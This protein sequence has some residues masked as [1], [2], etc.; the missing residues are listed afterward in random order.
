M[1]ESPTWTPPE[2]SQPQT[3]WVPPE[4]ISR[5]SEAVPSPSVSPQQVSTPSKDILHWEPYFNGTGDLEKILPKDQADAFKALAKNNPEQKDGGARRAIVKAFL[6]DQLP[7]TKSL[8]DRNLDV[9]ASAYGQ[10]NLGIK[11]HEVKAEDLYDSI[12]AH[13]KS[14]QAE[15]HRIQRMQD[16]RA[17]LR[18]YGEWMM[19]HGPE[20]AMRQWEDFWKPNAPLPEMKVEN[21]PPSV[22]V[23]MYDPELIAGVWNGGI[24]PALDS[25]T[26]T[27]G[28]AAMVATGGLSALE[29]AG[30]A[31]YA[32]KALT[33]IKGFFTAMMAKTLYDQTPEVMRVLN[34]PKSTREQK[35][36]AV[37]GEVTT[38]L[39]TVATGLSTALDL[40]PAERRASVANKVA[41]SESPA[42]AANIL[43]VEANRVPVDEKPQM[44]SA[45]GLLDG[46]YPEGSIA[47][48]PL[49]IEAA[50]KMA[51]DGTIIE[52]VSHD[53]IAAEGKEGFTLSNGE[54]ATRE[55]AMKVA[56]ASGQMLEDVPPET[57]ELHSHMVDMPIKAE[58][59]QSEVAAIDSAPASEHL[60]SVKK[61]S[62]NTQLKRMGFDPV[63]PSE[64]KTWSEGVKG[65]MDRF[66]KDPE[67]G[68]NLV[69]RAL[70]GETRFNT[71]D[72]WDS[73]VY[74][75]QLEDAVVAAEKRYDE[76]LR[77]GDEKAMAAADAE[78]YDKQATLKQASQAFNEVMGSEAGRALNARKA[79]LRE[80]FSPAALERKW[81]KSTGKAEVPENVQKELK[82]K[83]DK[84]AELEDLLKKSV[85]SRAKARPPAE[86]RVKGIG[87][88]SEDILGR[89]SSRAEEAR[90][91]LKA[92]A[93]RAMAGI[94]PTDL[95]DYAIVAAD[96]L[97]KGVTKASEIS[98]RMVS[99]FGEAIRPHVDSLIQ[100]AKDS[101]A[102]ERYAAAL[103]QR[104]KTLETQISN[105]KIKIEEGDLAKKQGKVDRPS[106]EAIEVLKQE[107]DA[108]NKQLA[109]ARKEAAK[110]SEAETIQKKV[111]ALQER[112][113]EKRRQLSEGAPATKGTAVN[114]PQVEAIELARQEL[115][116]VNKE[117][118]EAR[119]GPPV[120]KEESALK[121]WRTRTQKEIAR[122]EA[123]E[124]KPERVPLELPYT[125]E[126]LKLKERV[127]TLKKEVAAEFRANE[128]AR[129]P[130]WIKGVD[131]VKWWGET[132]ILGTLGILLK[133][134]ASATWKTLFAPVK[135]VFGVTA[136][137]VFPEAAKYQQMQ[138]QPTYAQMLATEAKAAKATVTRGLRAFGE[139]AL[140]RLTQEEKLFVPDSLPP[141]AKDFIRSIHRALHI[142]AQI[143]AFIRVVDTIE[144]NLK[145]EGLGHTLQDP[146]VYSAIRV[147][148]YLESYRAAYLEK[149]SLLSGG[150]KAFIR[151]IET[152]GKKY[153]AE[154]L[155][156]LVTMAIELDSPTKTVPVN[157]IGQ[158][159]ETAFGLP[160][161]TLEIFNAYRKGFE[162]MKKG[163]LDAAFRRVKNGSVGAL[164]ML[165]AWYAYENLGGSKT[166]GPMYDKP[167]K[168][169][170]PGMP[171]EGQVKVGE[172]TLPELG[173]H[174]ETWAAAQMVAS[175]R[176]LLDAQ[177]GKDTVDANSDAILRVILGEI[178]D[179][180]GLKQSGLLQM[181]Q[182]KEPTKTASQW[183]A[184]RIIPG[185]VAQIARWLDTPGDISLETFMSQPTKRYPRTGVEE[186][187]ARIPGLRE[188]VPTRRQPTT[189]YRQ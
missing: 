90:A 110:P 99:E 185:G 142:P 123:R 109:E 59:V 80:D 82:D 63:T 146:A 8:I 168:R 117:L 25:M 62:V 69:R 128:L 9:V 55:E 164:A 67:R 158:I 91:R 3:S 34:D 169:R 107:R 183:A 175:Y 124:P 73:Q 134:P 50:A 40:L 37:S 148:A 132:A 98:Q 106:P 18:A 58:A 74:Q 151:A 54:F 39:F 140:N 130:A 188:E 45:A 173:F 87:K 171:A 176:H 32:A 41:T 166:S 35:I 125:P 100:M 60:T 65:A 167:E 184:A 120:S 16:A 186:F 139:A 13:I 112:I 170:R 163:D 144:N 86:P 83:A 156:A 36:A 95:P 181:A 187:K 126:D 127:E 152:T 179:M 78:L 133:I 116:Q 28:A 27:G 5:R 111:D 149:D 56:K 79:M 30:V 14:G 48:A 92:K 53:K 22:A 101:I 177:Y 137:K 15:A 7:E 72:V 38:G 23:P 96:L 75:R 44:I 94:D 145:A 2:V 29:K 43:R 154:T 105:L 159:G 33:G 1:P 174:N 97:A 157:V 165:G 155:A 85:E 143:N 150:V 104:K 108:L 21:L 12:S 42:D 47:E 66:E 114:R 115:D 6:T 64:T 68:A 81:R 31:P 121:A 89:L 131:H 178:K 52:G 4:V 153:N 84:I 70:A 19:K 141:Q 11:D 17:Q 118:A 161:G 147:R 113:A 182:T 119:K 160:M 135:E 26:S 129:R 71:E 103:D 93:G 102:S 57:T 49:K 88:I 180:P 20:S 76:A 138:V 172:I 136:G 46:M 10:Q 24:K 51:E 162:G 61:A 122:L 77:S 189:S